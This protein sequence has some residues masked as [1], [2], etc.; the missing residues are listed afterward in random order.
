[1]IFHFECEECE[2][3]GVRVTDCATC[4]GTGEDYARPCRSCK[5][6]GERIASCDCDKHNIDEELQAG[7]HTD[8]KRSKQ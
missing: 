5:G 4:Y 7:L 3:T 2:D 6:S 1:M 8:N